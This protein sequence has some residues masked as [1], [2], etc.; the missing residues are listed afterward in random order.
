MPVKI[1]YNTQKVCRENL[2]CP[3]SLFLD[4]KQS[5]DAC[6]DEDQ[7]PEEDVQGQVG[8]AQVRSQTGKQEGDQS[9]KPLKKNNY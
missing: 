6:Q 3:D 4:S 5:R 7:H 9:G 2:Q 1:S 8:G